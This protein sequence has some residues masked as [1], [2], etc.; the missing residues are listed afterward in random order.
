MYAVPTTSSSGVAASTMRVFI[1]HRSVRR[2]SRRSCSSTGKPR[3]PRMIAA[4]IGRQMNGSEAKP[5]RLS[6]YSANPALLNDE[7]EWNSAC[8][9]ASPTLRP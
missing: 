5:I 6:L 7:T 3:P 4:Q 8:H 9:A 1:V 2:N